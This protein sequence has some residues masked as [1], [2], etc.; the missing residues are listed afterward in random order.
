[1][2]LGGENVKVNGVEGD[3]GRIFDDIQTG[4]GLAEYVKADSEAA[5]GVS[6]H[7]Q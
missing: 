1:M 7:T 6:M 2:H 3:G 5:P 4:A